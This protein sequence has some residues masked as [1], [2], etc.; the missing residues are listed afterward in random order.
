MDDS[1]VPSV[2]RIKSNLEKQKGKSLGLIFPI[3]SIRDGNPALRSQTEDEIFEDH[4][5]TSF[6]MEYKISASLLEMIFD[7]LV[8]AKNLN[9]ET[10]VSFL[11][12]YKVY[13]DNSQQILKVGFER[14]FSGDYI[15]CLHILTSQIERTFRHILEKLGIVTTVI[16][17]EAIEEKTLG[18]ILR[19][20]KLKELLGADITLYATALLVDKRGDNLRNDIAHGLIREEIC[21][22][23]MATS[24]LHIFLLLTRLNQG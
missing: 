18:T 12:S 7:E 4:L 15:S 24:L 14:Y 16:N 21:T 3:V 11:I 23:N 6:V 19:E 20:P 1:F 8:K 17:Q 10:L 5:V 2:Q 13:E 22:R 9:H